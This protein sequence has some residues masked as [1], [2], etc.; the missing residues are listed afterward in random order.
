MP[1]RQA[2]ARQVKGGPRLPEPTEKPLAVGVLGAGAP[3]SPLMAGA[4]AYLYQQKKTFDIFYT[5]GGGALLGLL[6]VAPGG[7]KRADE[8]LRDIVEFGVDD[9]IYKAFPVGYKTFIKRGF[10]TEQIHALADTLKADVKPRP[11]PGQVTI[12]EYEYDSTSQRRKRFYNDLIDLWATA[13]TPTRLGPTSLGL[14]EPL[15][16]LEKMIDFP[17]ANLPDSPSEVDFKIPILLPSPEPPGFVFASLHPGW[18]YVNA[19][20]L[21]ETEMRYFSNYDPKDPATGYKGSLT[22]ETIR[23]ALSFP[24]VYPPQEIKGDLYCE[25]ALIDP[26]NL[27]QATKTVIQKVEH[28]DQSKFRRMKVYL[29]DILGSLERELMYSQRTLWEAYGLSILTPVV[30]LA[31][32]SKSIFKL[33]PNSPELVT[34]PFRIPRVRRDR[35]LEWS[36][37]NMSALWDAGWEAAEKF[38]LEYPRHWEDLPDRRRP[39]P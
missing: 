1:T 11:F 32:Y 7:K 28:K 20:N 36:Y 12:P 30:S 18:F 19:Y 33:N 21:D 38:H 5:S 4:L 17:T 37:G 3:H 16:Y 10:F 25:G 31:K 15:L 35:P 39:P 14:C 27:P 13:I 26:L 34:V 29:F 24:F 6:F 2:K 9:R 23:A 8:A 22:P